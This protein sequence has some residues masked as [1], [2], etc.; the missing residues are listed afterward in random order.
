VVAGFSVLLH[1]RHTLPRLCSVTIVTLAYTT[2]FEAA[3]ALTNVASGTS[4]HTKVVIDAGAVP[5]FVQLLQS[6]SDDVREQVCCCV[7]GGRVGG[8]SMQELMQCTT[9][10]WH[11][12]MHV[13]VAD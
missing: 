10:E 7:I 13:K 6:P 8:G 5:I 11:T 9:L 2:Q 1:S 3:W 4:D 12:C